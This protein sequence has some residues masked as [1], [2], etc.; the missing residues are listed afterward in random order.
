MIFRHFYGLKG[1]GA[2]AARTL[3]ALELALLVAFVLGFWK[4]WTYGFVL[5]LHA[6]ST[7]SSFREYLTPWRDDHLMFFAAWPMLAGCYTL[8]ALRDSDVLLPVRRA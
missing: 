4:R 6:A 2:T 3:G 8:F 5:I 1:L 7:F